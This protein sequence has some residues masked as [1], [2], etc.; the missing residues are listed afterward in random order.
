MVNGE[1]SPCLP[2]SHQC[3]TTRSALSVLKIF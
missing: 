2:L 1:L 3:S